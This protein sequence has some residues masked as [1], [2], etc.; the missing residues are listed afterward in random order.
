MPILKKKV[1][2]IGQMSGMPDLNFPQFDS[3]AEMLRNQG[4]DVVNPADLDRAAYG[5]GK[6]PPKDFQATNEARRTAMM[7]DL[8]ALMECDA[9]F[10]MHGWSKGGGTHIENLLAKYIGL[11]ILGFDK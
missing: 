7:R 8:P 3:T 1:Y 11:E 2:I 6:C 10:R 9:I 5:W 4:W